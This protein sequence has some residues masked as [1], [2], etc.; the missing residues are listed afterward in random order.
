MIR[1]GLVL[2]LLMAGISVSLAQQAVEINGTKGQS[3]YLETDRGKI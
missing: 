2:L 1:L 3:D